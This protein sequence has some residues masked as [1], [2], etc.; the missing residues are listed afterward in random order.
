MI[1]LFISFGQN[2]RNLNSGYTYA[3]KTVD[4]GVSEMSVPTARLCGFAMQ[5]LKR[6]FALKHAIH[7]SNLYL[8]SIYT[9]HRIGVDPFLKFKEFGIVAVAFNGHLL[10]F[11]ILFIFLTNII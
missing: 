1:R 4:T 10:K 3:K 6:H 2:H 8:V 7:L 9:P 5:N 11:D